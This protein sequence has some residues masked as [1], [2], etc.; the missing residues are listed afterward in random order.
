MVKGSDNRNPSPREPKELP[1]HDEVV[2]QWVT[3]GHVPVVGHDSK[4]DTVRPSKKD[5]EEHLGPSGQ[6][7]D[8]HLPHGK[9]A[10][11]S[12]GNNVGRVA[13]FQH[14]QNK[15]EEVRW[16]MEGEI[17]PDGE[18]NGDVSNKTS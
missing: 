8:K 18:P 4:Q 2:M 13:N 14:G 7:G 10:S 16:G 6:K 3:D 12:Q 11:E 1:T 5:E 15:K 9:D 17:S